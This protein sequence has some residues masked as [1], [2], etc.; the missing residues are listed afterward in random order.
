MKLYILIAVLLKRFCNTS[1]MDV[2]KFHGSCHF[3]ELVRDCMG[4]CTITWEKGRLGAWPSFFLPVVSTASSLVLSRVS[5]SFTFKLLLDAR[6]LSEEWL[7][8][9]QYYIGQKWPCWDM[10]SVSQKLWSR[11]D[12]VSSGCTAENENRF[13]VLPCEET[14][15]PWHLSSQC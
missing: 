13:S 8:C 5:R 3:Y 15:S 2:D 10:S 11:L 9:S 12:W 6:V 14:C 7:Y 4:F 1:L